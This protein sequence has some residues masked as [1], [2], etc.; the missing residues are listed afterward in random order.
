MRISTR[1]K[2]HALTS[3]LALIVLIPV[4]LWALYLYHQAMDDNALADEILTGIFECSTLRDEYLLFAED[5][6]RNQWGDRKANLDRLLTLA[7]KQFKGKTQKTIL[8]DMRQK[9]DI[10]S[11]LFSRLIHAKEGKKN[12]SGESPLEQ[13]L[14]GQQ[15]LNASILYLDASR[16][17]AVTTQRVDLTY[18]RT[19]ILTVVIV[20]T[21]TLIATINLHTINR[22]LNKQLKKISQG[23]EIIAKGNLEHRIAL[24]GDDELTALAA[25]LN[26]MTEKVQ[27]NTRQLQAANSELEAFSY[28]VSHDLRAPLRHIN[29][30]V[31]L[32]CKR[33]LGSLDAKSRHYLQVIAASARKMGELIDDLLNFSRMGRVEMLQ[34]RVSLTTLVIEAQLALKSHLEGQDI[35]WD[36][37]PLPQVYGDPSMLRLVLV[38]LF[39]NAVKFSHGKAPIRIS[40][41]WSQGDNLDEAVFAV[42]D[43]GAG[44]DMR[45]VDKLFGLFQRLHSYEEFEGT[46]LGLANVQRIIHRHSGRIWAEGAVGKGATFYFS[47][48]TIKEV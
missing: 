26:S 7:D 1:L 3:V 30:F 28:S 31:E 19:L 18:Q 23:A 44:F 5:R 42:K 16:L 20:L 32:L 4:L 13:R 12:N 17:Q 25:T 29:G 35:I 48:P 14:L 8:A 24:Q 40:I 33:D 21:M 34:T 46:G 36:I 2:L 22:T 27:L 41:S 11:R 15:I 43:N 45:Y 38:N 6:P 37:V 39:S 47:L 9:F 10:S